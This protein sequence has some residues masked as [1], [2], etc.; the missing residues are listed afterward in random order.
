MS[1]VILN[2]LRDDEDYYGAF[3]KQFLSNSDI[4]ALLTNPKQFRSYSGDNVNYAKGRYFH[5]LI[6]EPEKAKD[7]KFIDVSTRNTKAYKEF[8]EH[9]KLS[10]AM[11][12]KEGEE[13]RGCVSSMTQNLAFFEGIRQEGNE[14]EV[15]AIKEIYGE[16]WK[17]KA[18]I[19][20]S[21]KL[22]DLKTTGK[23]DDFKY[24]ARKYNYDSQCYI[25]QELFGAFSV[26]RG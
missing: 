6:L 25:Y 15:P 11:L 14:Y 22:I 19:V 26:L 1:D 4:S 16:M 17:G 9:H 18:D 21:D 24:S 7:T 13:I 3:G 8:V 12:E 10:F 20:C 5:Q 2:R 23:I